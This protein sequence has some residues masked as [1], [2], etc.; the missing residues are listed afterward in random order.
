MRDVILKV[1]RVVCEGRVDQPVEELAWA[2][3][4][5][6]FVFH[7][8]PLDASNSI[9]R[10]RFSFSSCVESGNWDKD[11][12]FAGPFEVGIGKG[13]R[14]SPG[15]RTTNLTGIAGDRVSPCLPREALRILRIDKGLGQLTGLFRRLASPVTGE[16]RV[17]LEPWW[18]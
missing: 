9:D 18:S 12:G 6:A 11:A 3:V 4:G 2:P 7:Q 10:R 16:Q 8:V 17:R 15:V 1:P 5:R 13:N 14:Q